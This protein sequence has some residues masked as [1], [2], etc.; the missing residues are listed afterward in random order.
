MV[1]PAELENTRAGHE[2]EDD[3]G[4]SFSQDRFLIPM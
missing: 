2:H 4:S 3:M 1:E